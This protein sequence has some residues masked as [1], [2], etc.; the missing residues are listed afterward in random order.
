MFC[1]FQDLRQVLDEQKKKLEHLTAQG[2]ELTSGTDGTEVESTLDSLRNHWQEVN[3]LLIEKL[4]EP[5]GEVTTAA[6]MAET[7]VSMESAPTLESQVISD[8][9]DSGT[10]LIR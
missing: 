4:P 10:K 9:N 7:A 3:R 5:T 6:V 2:H 8:F 1:F